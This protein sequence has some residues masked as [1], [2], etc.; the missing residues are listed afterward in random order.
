MFVE[1]KAEPKSTCSLCGGPGYTCIGFPEIIGGPV[2]CA[3]CFL[4]AAGFSDLEW[5]L[6]YINK[7]HYKDSPP[8]RGFFKRLWD[9][10]IWD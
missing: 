9:S 2:M 5:D 8:K 4:K 7:N 3:I 1:W 10:H 6:D